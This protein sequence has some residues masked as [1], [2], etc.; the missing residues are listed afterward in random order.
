ILGATLIALTSIVACTQGA[1]APQ[2]PAK[3]AVQLATAAVVE[4]AAAVAGNAVSQEPKAEAGPETSK[5]MPD[6]V[7]QQEAGSA[8]AL[9][10]AYL[11]INYA[12]AKDLAALMKSPPGLDLLSARGS[13]AIDERT[14]TLLIHDTP[15]NLPALRELVARLDVQVDQVF[16]ESVFAMVDDDLI[17]EITGLAP[18]GG[19]GALGTLDFGLDRSAITAL[20]A[21]VNAN[22]AEVIFMPR[23]TVASRSQAS[24]EQSTPPCCAPG[25]PAN[26][27]LKFS[28][29]V[30]PD[31]RIRLGIGA[32]I[33]LIGTVLVVDGQRVP[34]INTKKVDAEILLDSGGTAMLD[35]RLRDWRSA[36]PEE[37]T[38]KRRLV[39]FITVRSL[40]TIVASSK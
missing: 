39:A 7:K 34:T 15:Q 10:A 11:K 22:R 40:P 31:K 9:E 5:P 23:F 30:R 27:R 17:R 26:L 6:T 38:S 35:L 21:G 13:I 24:I 29:I 14:N 16:I 12:S 32:D 33:S 2:Q 25:Q 20:E 8:P 3:P 36:A 1:D 18:P 4:Q 19:T 28:P 37:A